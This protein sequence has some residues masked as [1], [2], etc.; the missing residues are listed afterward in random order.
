MADI[1]NV[2]AC[3]TGGNTGLFPCA[4]NPTIFRRMVL[5]PKGYVIPASSLTRAASVRT[6]LRNGLINDT[7]GL[8]WHM[9]GMLTQFQDNTGDPNFEDRDGYQALAQLK[10]YNW[11][12]DCTL[13]FA[14]FAKWK[15]GYQQC[16][17]YYDWLFIDDSGNLIGTPKTDA[18]DA[19]GL[20]GISL[21]SF[22]IG[23]ALFADATHP[24]KFPMMLNIMN[25]V[26]LNANIA[27]VQANINPSDYEKLLIDVTLSVSTRA[28]TTTHLYVKVNYNGVGATGNALDQYGSIL[29]AAGAWLLTDNGSTLTPSAVA[30][31]ATYGDLDFTVSTLT[32]GHTITYRLNLPS[33]VANAP[34]YAP[35]VSDTLTTT[36]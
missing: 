17:A 9:S 29:A 13:Q 6:L 15:A 14:Q 11:K 26:E 24:V 23:D 16:Q 22:T 34:Y 8:R 3:A 7:P 19:I 5:I 30:Y 10:P 36:V 4:F 25:N 1:L 31:N 2:A 35:L 20:G 27:M 28:N 12:Y 21:Y 33:V 18:D 32:S